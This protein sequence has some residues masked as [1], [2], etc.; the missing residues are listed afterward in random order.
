MKIRDEEPLITWK[1]IIVD[2]G[3]TL[4][5]I[6]D[7]LICFKFGKTKNPGSREYDYLCEGYNHFCIIGTGSSEMSNLG[8]KILVKHFVN[9]NV[10]KKWIQNKR[11]GGAGNPEADT[12]YIAINSNETNIDDIDG[13]VLP[14][15]Y[16]INL[17]N[18]KE[19]E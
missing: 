11:D 2:V 7:K 4:L 9:H 13:T 14:N 16:P 15:Y 19:D 1:N 17:N 3:N 8:E 6:Q 10:L 5:D 12:L 18:I